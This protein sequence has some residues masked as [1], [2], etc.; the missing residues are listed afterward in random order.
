MGKRRCFE[1]NVIKMT[2]KC[3][4]SYRINDQVCGCEDGPFTLCDKTNLYSCS[5]SSLDH[6]ATKYISFQT[7]CHGFRELLP[8][9]IDGTNHSDETERHYWKYNNIYTR[10]N[11]I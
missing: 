1:L 4:S 6:C 5:M 2:K 9:V 7:I 3:I 11:G 10:C 8:I